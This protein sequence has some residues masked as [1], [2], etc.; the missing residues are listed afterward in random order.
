MYDYEIDLPVFRAQLTACVIAGY[1]TLCQHNRDITIHLG[2]GRIDDFNV[3]FSITLNE[4][5][6]RIYNIE[7]NPSGSKAKLLRYSV[8][9]SSEDSD[10]EDNLDEVLLLAIKN[11]L[12]NFF[13]L[14]L[15]F[16]MKPVAQPTH[17]APE[18][19]Q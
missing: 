18:T 10:T 5:P 8:N 7:V 13:Y 17:E 1:N 3:T 2:L 9:E 19:I 6:P 12:N 16:A 11:A 14:A 4:E 15:P